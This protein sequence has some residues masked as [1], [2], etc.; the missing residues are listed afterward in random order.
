MGQ[1]GKVDEMPLQ[2]QIVLEPFE[3][4]AIDF[5]GLFYPPCQKAHILVGTD[6]VTKWVES[7]VV[8]R[9]TEQVVEDLLFEEIFARYG[10]SRKIVLDGGVQ[11]TYHMIGNAEIRG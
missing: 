5:V 6:Y 7:K 1:P 11:F 3:K 4:R 10:T 2:P 8:I 9:E